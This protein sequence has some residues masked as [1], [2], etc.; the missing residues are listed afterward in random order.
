MEIPALVIQGL[1][2]QDIGLAGPNFFNPG[3][4]LP[5]AR[6]PLIGDLLGPAS[7]TIPSR[8][9][10]YGFALNLMVLPVNHPI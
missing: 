4:L 7:A 10:R 8:E 5:L 6:P 2:P 3:Y 1:L 9:W